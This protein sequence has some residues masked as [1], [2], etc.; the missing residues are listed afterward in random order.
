MSD[1]G[2]SLL[3]V[4]LCVLLALVLRVLQW[5]LV[6]ADNAGSGRGEQSRADGPHYPQSTTAHAPA[7]PR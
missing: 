7:P 5:W 2:W 1:F 3:L 6:R 4:G